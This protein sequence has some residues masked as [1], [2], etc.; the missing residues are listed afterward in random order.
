MSSQKLF[1]QENRKAFLPNCIFYDLCY[2]ETMQ[3]NQSASIKSPQ[4]RASMFRIFSLLVF[5]AS[6]MPVLAM[7][8][9][10]EWSAS[11]KQGWQL[12]YSGDFPQA[13]QILAQAARARSLK[14][15]LFL[16]HSYNHGTSVAG[17][18]SEN[19][20]IFTTLVE[21]L[22]EQKKAEFISKEQRSTL[23]KRTPQ[24]A[25]QEGERAFTWYVEKIERK[26]QEK[27][28]RIEADRYVRQH[29]W[30]KEVVDFL[31]AQKHSPFRS[32]RT[33]SF[34]TPTVERAAEE[35]AKL[36]ATAEKPS[37]QALDMLKT[38]VA[39]YP[40]AA[41]A[42][43]T[44]LDALGRDYNR[45]SVAA[46]KELLGLVHSWAC[47]NKLEELKKIYSSYIW[48]VY[49]RYDYGNNLT[50]EEKDE[51]FNE[52]IESLLAYNTLDSAAASKLAEHFTKRY[53]EYLYRHTGSSDKPLR[54]LATLKQINYESFE[55]H[56][57][58]LIS[59]DKLAAI[60]QVLLQ[61]PETAAHYDK[62]L[63]S[64]DMLI[65]KTLA[66]AEVQK[67]PDHNAFAAF[68]NHGSAYHKEYE[69]E[70]LRALPLFCKNASMYRNVQPLFK[71]ALPALREAVFHA[72]LHCVVTTGTSYDH[73]F[74]H[75]LIDELVRENLDALTALDP[76]KNYSE[77]FYQQ[78]KD[79]NNDYAIQKLF[80][81]IARAQKPQTATLLGRILREYLEAKDP[82]IETADQ[83]ALKA[84]VTAA[85]RDAIAGGS[86]VITLTRI[87]QILN[88]AKETGFLDYLDA[89]FLQ[90]LSRKTA[91]SE[92]TP[93]AQRAE[94]LN[95]LIIQHLSG[96][97]LTTDVLHAE[98]AELRKHILFF[99][100]P[101]PFRYWATTLFDALNPQQSYF[102]QFAAR[103][104]LIDIHEQYA[105]LP[106]CPD[107]ITRI[108]PRL[109]RALRQRYEQPKQPLVHETVESSFNRP[110][111]APGNLMY[112]YVANDDGQYRGNGY[113]YRLYAC[114]KGTGLPVWASPVRSAEKEY[115]FG[116]CQGSLWALSSVE[117]EKDENDQTVFAS[118]FLEYDPSNGDIKNEFTVGIREK[119]K[120]VFFCNLYG[121]WIITDQALHIWPHHAPFAIHSIDL[122]ADINTNFVECIGDQIVF[123]SCGSED[124]AQIAVY[125]FDGKSYRIE[126]GA[127]RFFPPDVFGNQ[128]MFFMAPS[129]E[130]NASPRLLCFNA[131]DG[132]PLWEYAL[133]TTLK[134]AVLSTDGTILYVLTEK[135][136]LALTT[137]PETS[138]LNRLAFGFNRLLW[139]TSIEDSNAFSIKE[140]IT[141]I[142][143]SENG[144]T[145]YGLHDYNEGHLYQFD[146][147]SG[148]KMYLYPVH[149]ARGHD[150]VGFHNN[151][152]YI[153]SY[154][155]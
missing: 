3:Y 31:A 118:R 58:E 122:P 63:L 109:Y 57:N 117:E 113:Y 94:F 86:E 104:V 64:R 16:A 61:H 62:T 51:L 91:L 133:P 153:R 70:I 119:I 52:L 112:G 39:S 120:K 142:Q 81:K 11:A 155:Y 78:S 26:T 14:A 127:S 50:Q 126:T 49:N 6:T 138:G 139:Q 79:N 135:E 146:T 97:K 129:A 68:I 10:E 145:L 4:T 88:I 7:E 46:R 101:S 77:C 93:L 34:K 22:K 60:L 100:T 32:Y 152:P 67:E 103:R 107:G 74:Q 1:Q 123:T 24:Q 73:Y 20:R 111:F 149:E 85:L 43:R 108:Y 83:K 154:S 137:S 13:E 150:F 21:Q 36:A 29:P 45:P 80:C 121:K 125:N 95:N 75:S 38:T 2:A 98:L 134:K 59:S 144:N 110:L 33:N 42:Y 44:I 25:A 41:D 18:N 151:K 23:W 87:Q 72:Y 128:D 27:N 69:L 40:K 47:A 15:A 48:N 116:L 89:G 130:K 53:T 66:S 115:S 84:I 30:Y 9:A 136:L 96:K 12:A 105:D 17:Q 82:K 76:N 55:K 140:Q 54:L 148:A 106:E 90:E 141:D 19:A 132:R 37:P 102:E 147:K 8:K 99:L 5:F 124:D 143:L 35:L 71:S 56:A 28:S 92:T 131:Q 114:D 65:Q